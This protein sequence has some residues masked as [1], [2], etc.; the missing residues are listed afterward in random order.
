MYSFFVYFCF[1][2]LSFFFSFNSLTFHHENVPPSNFHQEVA[3]DQYFYF[4]QEFMF[5]CAC[6]PICLPVCFLSV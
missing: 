3:F 4:H 1:L 2:F 5:L 6:L